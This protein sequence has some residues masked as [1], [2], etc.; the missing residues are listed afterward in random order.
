MTIQNAE[1]TAWVNEIKPTEWG[2]FVKLSHERRIFNEATQGWETVGRDYID[3][4][5]TSEFLPILEAN[6]LVKI[7]CNVDGTPNAYLSKTGEAR[8]SL[9]ISITSVS[10][11]ER[12]GDVE[13]S[14][15]LNTSLAPRAWVPND[16]NLA[17]TLGATPLDEEAPF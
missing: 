13:V 9:K 2:A 12:R 6:K 10:P 1:F 8:A 11:V 3:A 7:I 17:A 5:A 15:Q 14:P 4:S 16:A